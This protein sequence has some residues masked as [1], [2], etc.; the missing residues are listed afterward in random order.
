M[1]VHLVVEVPVVVLAVVHVEV[2]DTVV[3]DVVVVA[4]AE[5]VVPVLLVAV[6]LLRDEVVMDV[7]VIHGLYQL[8]VVSLIRIHPM[9]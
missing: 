7:A 1:V 5:R 3:P 9:Q 8:S 2:A 4:V 6:I